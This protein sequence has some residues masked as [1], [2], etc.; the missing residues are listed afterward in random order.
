MCNHGCQADRQPSQ[1]EENSQEDVMVMSPIASAMGVVVDDLKDVPVFDPAGQGGAGEEIL[2]LG[3]GS[4]LF[5]D[6]NDA[7]G[8]G[9]E[10]EESISPFG[11]SPVLEDDDDEHLPELDLDSTSQDDGRGL[12]F[13]LILAG[14]AI[15]LAAVIAHLTGR[16]F[17]LR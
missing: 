17:W 7:Q 8:L 14:V 16:A 12:V 6:G 13:F 10:L 9:E 11:L 3:L 1:D 15:G 5:G 4:E 2:Q